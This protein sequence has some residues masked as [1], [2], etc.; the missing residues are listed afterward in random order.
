[1]MDRIPRRSGDQHLHMKTERYRI[2]VRR[3][4]L[5][6]HRYVQL[7]C[8]AQG[9]L[10]HL[11]LNFRADVW[12]RFRSWLRT[13]NTAQPPS[14]AVVAQALRNSLPECLPGGSGDPELEEFILRQVDLDRCP[15]LAIT[16]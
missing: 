13:M 4:M 14:E 11:A 10:Q 1:M 9:L 6:Y 8:I 16:A 2:L 3:K 7:G 12:S 15:A 5:A